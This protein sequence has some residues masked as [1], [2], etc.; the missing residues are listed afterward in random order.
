MQYLHNSTT[1]HLRRT[2]CNVSGYVTIF[3]MKCQKYP[4]KDRGIEL[5]PPDFSHHCFLIHFLQYELN[6]PQLTLYNLCIKYNV[7]KYT[8]S[9]KIAPR[10]AYKP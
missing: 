4:I 2:V 1:T 3:N 9:L 5:V 7:A 8:R 10:S 6:I